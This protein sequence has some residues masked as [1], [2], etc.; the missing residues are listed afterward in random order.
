MTQTTTRK[1]RARRI[2]AD[3]CHS[4]ARNL[5]LKNPLG[6]L[7]LCMLTLYVNG[8]GRCRVS[9]PQLADDCELNG[10]TIRR[11]LQWL[12]DIGA[13]TKFPCWLDEHGRRNSDQRGKRTTDDIV[14]MLEADPDAI[15]ARAAGEE[16]YEKD[17]S[18][19]QVI[20]P[21]PCRGLNSEAETASPVSGQSDGTTPAVDQPPQSSGGLISEPEPEPL[22]GPGISNPNPSSGRAV[23]QNSDQGSAEPEHFTEFLTQYPGYRVMDRGKA[24]QFFT[25]LNEADRLLARAAVP[26]L[27]EDLRK[28]DRRPK[29][30]YKWLRDRG[31][32]L[33]P[34]AK[35]PTAAPPRIWIVEDSDQHRALTVASMVRDIA[36]PRPL[37]DP[38]HGRG[39]WRVGEVPADLLALAQ[40][41]SLPIEQWPIALEDSPEF[42]AWSKRLH[43]WGGGNTRPRLVPNGETKPFEWPVGTFKDVPVRVSGIPTPCRWPPRKD[44]KLSAHQPE[45]EGAA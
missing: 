4:W 8:E 45:T 28:A 32:D 42:Y 40:F 43:E 22:P 21:L 15:A 27:T 34:H 19:Q 2:A 26:Y 5:Q 29:D 36:P 9:I 31:F 37:S 44:G 33:Y 25:A 3:E 11:R 7:L 1:P 39:F 12:E 18:E 38:E 41:D 14:L 23:D 17:E 24:L 20:S 13:I 10:E 16:P 30:A 35:L 6:K